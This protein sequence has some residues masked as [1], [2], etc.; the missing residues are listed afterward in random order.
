MVCLYR[1]PSFVTLEQN[2]KLLSQI[3]NLPT[4]LDINLVVVG[5]LNLPNVDWELGIVRK[6]VGSTD[7]RYIIQSEYLDVFMSK[8][9]KW[10]ISNEV[11][12]IRKVNDTIQQSTLDQVLSNNESLI[13]S[14]DFAPPLGKSDHKS[15]LIEL[16]FHHNTEYLSSIKKN[17]FKV[18]S[19]FIKT[20]GDCIDWEY[21]A[22]NLS[23]ESMWQE[24][25]AKM[26][27]IADKVPDRILKTNAAGDVLQKLP[28]DC[29]KLVRKRKE[30]DQTWNAFDVT[31]SMT[32][33]HTALQKQ[34][35]Y[36]K[37]EFDAK[38][39]YEKKIVNKLKTNSKPF[40]NYLKSKNKIKR[41]VSSLKDPTGRLT[42]SP[43]ETA[44]ALAD[45]FHSVFT[46]E[47]YGPLTEDAYMSINHIK[48][49]MHDLEI[50]P[51]DVRKLLL[52]LNINK[53]MGPDKIH[54]KLLKFLA[55]NDNFMKS[56]TIL[57]NACIINEE[58]PLIWKTAHVVPLHKK[59][60]VHLANNYRPI[61]LTCILCKI[62]EKFIRKH[63][64]FHVESFISDK[65]HGFTTGRSCLSNLLET[66]DN[67]YEYL[68]E[69]NCA[70]ILYF[71]FSKAFDSVPHHRLIIKLEAMGFNN[72][73]L[74]IIKN[75]LVD[76]SMRVTVGDSLSKAKSVVS[77]VPQ[78]S[79]MG[80]L[81]FLL[82]INDLPESMKGLV[83]IFADDLK[84]IVN[85]FKLPDIEADLTALC[86]WETKWLL[87][88]NL[89]KC[90]VLHIGKSNPQN[91]YSFNGSDLTSTT[92]EKDLGVYFNDKFTFTDAI[93]AFVS[94]AKSRLFWVT[95]NVI[96]RDPDVMLKAYKSIVRPHLEYCCQAWSP[97]ARH[98]NWKMIMEIESVQRTFTRLVKGMDLLPY[99]ERLQKLGLTTLLE[100]RMRGDLLETFKILSKITNYGDGFF[101]L[102]SR[103]NNLVSRP[104]TSNRDFFSERVIKFWNK[105]PESVKNKNS[106]NS[107]KNALDSFRKNGI[108]NNL[109][110]QFW[111]QGH[112]R[113]T[114]TVT[115]QVAGCKS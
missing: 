26:Q 88:F 28:W 34:S 107:F 33:F 36:Q 37:C 108:T 84:M 11:T 21:S 13:N 99:S 64:L 110:G 9:L 62:Y 14:V 91:V 76:R 49:D 79:V 51:G 15:M 66:I 105:L 35:E 5:D 98:G 32:N 106:V 31:P 95:R 3:A 19:E 57:F 68:S 94:K 73:I 109:R 65:Q 10:H 46:E 69:G 83:K 27:S 58:I 72:N 77:G 25:Y 43:Q 63:I 6:P 60:S 90:F 48:G 103:T 102:S 4:S 39:K 40:Y 42:K 96:S 23:V 80:P 12:R 59:G 101:N 114:E 71:D 70:D 52:E 47:Q 55:E 41:T 113:S 18:D 38:V 92:K 86:V 16:N 67:V 74:N 75:F 100:R 7:K 111:E 104:G 20:N 44:D 1:S 93:S 30:K 85:P 89:D 82:F 53:A 29:S 115:T 8:S 61:S 56:L 78:G 54:P 112:Q 97:N 24:L 87:K 2:E 45:F 81:L 17:W 22:T 50:L